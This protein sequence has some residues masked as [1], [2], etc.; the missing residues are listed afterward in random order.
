MKQDMHGRR[1]RHAALAGG[2]ALLLAA[3][4][5]Q[6]ACKVNIGVLLAL[7][8]SMAEIGQDNL[9]SAQ[10]AIK[11][12]NAA[13]G[14]SGCTVD[15]IVYDSQTEP[16]VAVNQAKAL[17]DL[18]GVRVIFGSNSSGTTIAELRSVTAPAKVLLVSPSAAST[19]FTKLAKEGYTKGLFYRG[20][21]SVGG[22]GPVVAYVARHMAGWKHVSIVYVNNAFGV[23]YAKETIK[24]FEA[25]GGK[26]RLIPYNSDQPDYQSIVTDA[27]KDKPEALVLLA[28]P[29]GGQAI[30]RDWLQ[31]GGP[32]HVL[33]ADSVATQQF[34]DKSGGKLLDGG[35]SIKDA[36]VKSPWYALYH[37]NFVAAYKRTP[38]I[39]YDTNSY[40]AMAITLLAMD[41][42]GTKD[43]RKIFAAAREIT[44]PGGLVV[45]PT[46]AG[47]KA[48]LAAIAK[49]KKIHY[50]GVTGA[51]SI[52]QYGDV[53]NPVVV[54]RIKGGK[55]DYYKTLGVDEVDSIVKHHK[56]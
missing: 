10:L 42:A 22:E 12:V 44:A 11:D 2:L 9:R 26:A 49:G 34:V 13:G 4:A 6:A 5:S 21:M 43:A 19:S 40:D 39:P 30:L 33:L 17:V 28:H 36:A 7:T 53:S 16:T 41:Q 14:V 54:G 25:M 31:S 51:L 52:N 45:H 56:L 35:W 38:H 50:V 29:K 46:P 15:P 3:G 1:A 23:T 24:A 8:G 55:L 32:Q 20:V 18:K 47:F 48:A 37:K 27:L